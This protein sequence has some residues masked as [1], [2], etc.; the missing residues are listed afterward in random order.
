MQTQYHFKT[1]CDLAKVVVL[2]DGRI[3]LEV[4]GAYSNEDSPIS[5]LTATTLLSGDELV[6]F[7]DL[8]KKLPKW[9]FD[10]RPAK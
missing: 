10:I 8:I 4:M 9:D 1:I 7:N 6:K 5:S 3:F 2:D